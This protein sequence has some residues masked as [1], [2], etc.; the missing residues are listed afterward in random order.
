MWLAL[1]A[2]PLTGVLIHS[3]VDFPLQIPSLQ[4]ISAVPLGQLSSS[5]GIS[6]I[7]RSR[8]HRSFGGYAIGMR[9]TL[10]EVAELANS[11]A[12]TLND[13]ISRWFPQSR[14]GRQGNGADAGCQHGR[15][16]RRRDGGRLPETATG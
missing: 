2:L 12:C 15:L 14:G 10:K 6:Q 16:H 3:L 5:A 13:K 11:E 7:R 1:C 4:L 8:W 9:A